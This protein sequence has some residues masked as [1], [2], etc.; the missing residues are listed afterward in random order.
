MDIYELIENSFNNGDYKKTIELCDEILKEDSSSFEANGYK[1]LA[2]GWATTLD[3]VK[4]KECANYLIESL[5]NCPPDLLSKSADH[6]LNE[7]VSLGKQIIKGSGDFYS[8]NP[9]E[10]IANHYIKNI[11]EVIDALMF[12]LDCLNQDKLKDDVTHE[13]NV[14]VFE[15]ASKAFSGKIGVDYDCNNHPSLDDFNTFF[16]RLNSLFNIL[17]LSSALAVNDY[18][19]LKN[20]YES[21]II[22]CEELLLS[23]AWE[24][25]DEYGW[26]IVKR[27]SS[28]NYK[29]V[30]DKL[31][32]V[33]KVL[34]ELYQT[35]NKS[36]DRYF[37]VHD[38]ILKLFDDGLKL[39]LKMDETRALI[40]QINDDAQIEEA[41]RALNEVND[42]L[43]EYDNAINKLRYSLFQ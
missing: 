11:K 37:K 18:A 13:M 43:N 20:V 5:R 27:L 36:N 21:M 19:L 4:L 17:D 25:D 39:R 22:V 30:L 14:L 42:V 40:K 16:D 23:K 8:K 6:Y 32:L 34:D 9:S 3:N 26:L 2:L 28:N 33:L 7:L 38:D 15:S 12:Y 35:N 29:I 41:Y 24:K 31:K 10:Q 1:G